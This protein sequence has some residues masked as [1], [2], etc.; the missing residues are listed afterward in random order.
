MTPTAPTGQQ[1]PRAAGRRAARRNPSTRLDVPQLQAAIVTVTPQVARLQGWLTAAAGQ[2]DTAHRRIG[3]RRRHRP[4]PDRRRLARAGP[5]H[6]RQRPPGRSCGPP[7]CCATL[8]LVVAAVLDGVLTPAQA[9]V[10]TRLVG[11]ID[12][13][14]AGRV[15]AAA[16]RGRRHDGPRA[17][18][19]CG[20]PTRSPPTANPPRSRPRPRAH[21]KRYLTSRR[22][23]DGSLFGRFRLT[24]E[25]SEDAAHRPGTA[26]AQ[27]RRHRHAAPPGNAA[28]TPSS[29]SSEQVL[30]HGELPDA[31]G[32]RP[33]LSYV[34]P[35]DWAAGQHRP[36]PP[37]PPADRAAPTTNPLTF[38]DTVDAALPGHGGIR[39]A[40]GLRDR[41]VDRPADPRPHRDAAVRRP[42]HPRPAQPRSDRS[43]ASNPCATASPPPNAATSPPATCTA[44][45]AAAPDPPP[46][47]T[48][49]TS[50]HRADG[51][52][53]DHGQP[54]PALPTASRPVAPG[55][56]P[57]PPPPRPLAPRPAGAPPPDPLDRPVR[58]TA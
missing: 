32:L 35:A 16:D 21:D 15:A 53:D 45:P 49:T 8:P 54:R 50:D 34:L 39:A 1:R 5:A 3:R 29:S 43:P 44:S 27:G 25:D 4:A 2:L 28:P 37:A 48:P 42:H 9:A 19:A 38:A 40:A 14:G 46:C 31:G 41:R 55:Q 30:R 23:A 7:G 22:D 17:S 6:H 10:L 11:K 13:R 12:A 57:A 24:A 52:A 36:K 33:Q 58:R 56:A 47:A 51:G 20:S 18:S 26:R